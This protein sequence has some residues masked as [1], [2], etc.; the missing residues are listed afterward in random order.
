MP[1][2]TY[3]LNITLSTNTDS[4]SKYNKEV[5]G[6]YIDNFN[7]ISTLNDGNYDESSV[8]VGGKLASLNN[9]GTATMLDSYVKINNNEFYS[10]QSNELISNVAFIYERSS[11]IIS[12]KRKFD[13]VEDKPSYINTGLISNLN[14]LGVRPQLCKHSE[15]AT[16]LSS[17]TSEYKNFETI[18][19]FALTDSTIA[20]K[21]KFFPILPVFKIYGYSTDTLEYIE[22]SDNVISVSQHTGEIELEA[23]SMSHINIIYFVAPAT[24]NDSV[25]YINTDNKQYINIMPYAESIYSEINVH[26]TELILTTEE[27]SDCTL[28]PESMIDGIELSKPMI[29]NGTISNKH[30]AESIYS[31]SPSY[32]IYDN[33]IETDL[34]LNLPL[35]DNNINMAIVGIFNNSGNKRI[36][37]MSIGVDSINPDY[38]NILTAPSTYSTILHTSGSPLPAE[39][40]GQL[41][42]SINHTT[43]DGYG[44]ILPAWADES[45]ITI[46]KD[47]G[48]TTSPFT[49]YTFIQP[50][51]IILD[52]EY[53]KKTDVYNIQFTSFVSPIISI[54]DN[55]SHKA[56][57]NTSGDIFSEYSN[58]E[59]IYL[60]CKDNVL[61]SYINK[62]STYDKIYFKN[63]STITID[64]SKKYIK[65]NLD[66]YKSLIL[67]I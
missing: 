2:K 9:N 10:A 52:K 30:F 23:S 4:S 54:V 37:V 32:N 8:I 15:I 28:F 45:S 58:L 26:N 29:V 51:I 21:T 34:Y 59:G 19:P 33:L 35:V 18:E 47:D 57:I 24:V 31:I 1:I 62:M 46:T 40:N 56:H 43:D 14:L 39:N 38:Q 25:N 22:L 6:D 3:S 7:Y 17:I 60:L 27:T 67:E 64:V 66:K 20:I 61:I 65:T 63:K 42:Y 53:T 44:I 55:F 41:S 49:D 5:D 11:N 16:F 50:D 48:I 13:I 36:S 12:I